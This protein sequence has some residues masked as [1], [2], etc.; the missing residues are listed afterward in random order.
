M[1]AAIALCVVTLMASACS[2]HNTFAAGKPAVSILEATGCPRTIT[3][4]QDVSNSKNA[5]GSTLLPSRTP[6]GVFS[7]VYGSAKD[8]GKLEGSRI[9]TVAQASALATVINRVHLGEDMGVHSCPPSIGLVTIFAFAYRGDPDVD[10]WWQRDGCQ[11]LDNGFKIGVEA[12]N[13]SFYSG[14]MG[15]IQRLLPRAISD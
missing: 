2:T 7:C 11:S 3:G 13:P 6:T 1:R 5:R 4:Y 10:L 15:E 9:L 8:G 12:A 14:F